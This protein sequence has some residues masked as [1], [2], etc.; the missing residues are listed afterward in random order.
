MMPSTSVYYKKTIYMRL[1]LLLT[2]GLVLCMATIASSN[3][4]LH[5]CRKTEVKPAPASSVIVENS[6]LLVDKLL[7][8]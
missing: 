4:C 8:I 7:I 1:R 5:Y 3:E 2:L 6:T